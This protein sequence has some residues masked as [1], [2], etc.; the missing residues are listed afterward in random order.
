[1]TRAPRLPTGPPPAPPRP[2]GLTCPVCR[3]PTRVIETRA[4]R[5]GVR[6]RRRCVDCGFTL[7]THE[8][9]TSRSDT[10]HI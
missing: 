5:T 2:A 9:Y 7:T 4:T 3:A 8:Q 1:M 10:H 6:R